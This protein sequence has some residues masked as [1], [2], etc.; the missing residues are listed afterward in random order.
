MDLALFALRLRSDLL[1]RHLGFVCGFLQALVNEDVGSV[2]DRVV[3]EDFGHFL[4]AELVPKPI[5]SQHYRFVLGVELNNCDFGNGSDI[6][7]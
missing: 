3:S 4:P 6:V 2:F 7:S 5:R 1:D